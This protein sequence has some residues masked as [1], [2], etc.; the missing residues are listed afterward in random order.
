MDVALLVFAIFAVTCAFMLV[1][2][3]VRVVHNTVASTHS[4]G[5]LIDCSSSQILLQLS[6]VS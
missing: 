3:A 1:Q 6:A 2:V 5:S 4:E